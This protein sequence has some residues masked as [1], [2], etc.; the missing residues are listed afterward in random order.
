MLHINQVFYS[1]IKPSQGDELSSSS[2]HFT[3]NRT[4]RSSPTTNLPRTTRKRASVSPW[5]DTRENR[6]L[7]LLRHCG[8]AWS[9]FGT[10]GG[11]VTHPHSC[12]IQVFIA[13]AWQQARGGDAR[14]SATRHSTAV[15]GSVRRKYHFVYCCIVA[16]TCFGVAVLAWRKHTI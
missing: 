5:S 8:N 16:G 13:V 12:V 15:F 2:I 4:I 7:L 1:H 11:H 9:Q 3:S 6:A 14:R 10:R